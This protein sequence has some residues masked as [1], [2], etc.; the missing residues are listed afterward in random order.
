MYQAA[1]VLLFPSRRLICD[2][3]AN[4]AERGVNRDTVSARQLLEMASALGHADAV[5][6]L[7][8]LVATGVGSGRSGGDSAATV[9]VTTMPPPTT[10]TTA[11]TTTAGA[12]GAPLLVGSSTDASTAPPQL[13]VS[14]SGVA[15]GPGRASSLLYEALDVAGTEAEHGVQRTSGG[16]EQHVDATDAGATGATGATDAGA[17]DAGATG[18]QGTSSGSASDAEVVVTHDGAGAAAA[19]ADAPLATTGAGARPRSR[20][21]SAFFSPT[22]TSTSTSTSPPWGAQSGP[23]GVLWGTDGEL[24][25]G[26][27]HLSVMEGNMEAALALARRYT[28]GVGV[29]RC[30][31][32][33]SFYAQHAAMEA[34]RQHERAGQEPNNEMNRLTEENENTITTGAWVWLLFVS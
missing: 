10:T 26:L 3:H 34:M 6:D 9:A 14:T 28:S 7:A 16:A 33:A 1:Q 15:T 2:G 25:A 30:E 27:Y 17:T 19:G 18:A 8:F 20:L 23:G 21:A 29:G 22:S 12:S 31:L 11:T 13:P 4:W 5:N 32:A 24:G